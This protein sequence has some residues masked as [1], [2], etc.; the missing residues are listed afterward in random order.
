[1]GY[2]WNFNIV[3]RNFDLLVE[4]LY[5]TLTVTSISLVFGLVIGL[6]L[7]MMRLAQSRLFS[8]PAGIVIE[9]LRST[10]PLVQLFWVFLRYL[11][12]SALLLS[13]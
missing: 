12:S 6:T 13:R 9:F 10:P 11:S 2:E 4:G 3:L 5:N 1:M 7:A 8:I